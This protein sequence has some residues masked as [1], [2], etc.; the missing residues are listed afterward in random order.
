[1]SNPNDEQNQIL[2]ELNER[3]EQLAL[4]MEKARFAEYVQLLE[5]PRKLLWNHLVGGIARGVGIAI[6]FT[7]LTST[8]L[9][10]LQ[11]LGALDLPI[12]GDYIA[13][14][15]K[16]VQAQLEGRTY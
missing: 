3:I 15:V 16:H 6:G 14:I 2:R 12:V 9:Y 8:L 7:V 5:R 11:A 4:N 13:Q 1:M 10:V